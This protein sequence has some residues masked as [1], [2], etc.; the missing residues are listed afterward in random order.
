MLTKKINKKNEAMDSS[1]GPNC[2]STKDVK[3]CQTL[4][5]RIGKITRLNTSIR[6]YN[7]KYVLPTYSNKREIILKISK[8]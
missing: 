8:Y 7:L 1:L 2:I 4:I 5:V 3:K 6:A